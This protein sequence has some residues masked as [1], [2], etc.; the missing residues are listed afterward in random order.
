MVVCSS[1]NGL[2]PENAERFAAALRDPSLPDDACPAVR[3]SVFGCG[4]TDWAATYQAVPTFLDTELERHGAQRFHPRGAGDAHGDFDAQYRQWHSA[5]WSDLESALDLPSSAVTPAD[6]G[7]LSIS[8]V[9][10]QLANP[11]VLSY[12]AV[13]RPGPREP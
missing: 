8:I 1:Y 5:L 9:N 6:G 7:G 2:P 11:V 4:D 12:R 10:R 13:P 3:Y